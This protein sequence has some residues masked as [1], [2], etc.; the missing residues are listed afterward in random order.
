MTV[1]HLRADRQAD[2]VTDAFSGSSLQPGGTEN[3]EVEK[4]R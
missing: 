3:H 1:D 4:D 2:G